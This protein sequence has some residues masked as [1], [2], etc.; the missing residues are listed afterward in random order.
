MTESEL[1]SIIQETNSQ[2]AVLYGHVLT[3]SFAV[4]VDQKATDRFFDIAVQLGHMHPPCLMITRIP[5]TW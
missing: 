2:Y 3:I 1:T 4:I 5:L